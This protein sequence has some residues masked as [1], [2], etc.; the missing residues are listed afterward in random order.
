MSKG[1]ISL[2]DVETIIPAYKNIEVFVQEKFRI[3][4][5]KKG[6]GNTDNIGTIKANSIEPFVFGAGPF[7]F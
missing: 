3:C 5:D 6:S 2:K 7:L 4:G 1:K